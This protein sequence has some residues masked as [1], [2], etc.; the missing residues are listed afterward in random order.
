MQRTMILLG[1]LLVAT[2]GCNDSGGAI[3]G[4]AQAQQSRGNDLQA[5]LSGSNLIITTD[6]NGDLTPTTEAG[7]SVGV[8]IAKGSGS[9][10]FQLRVAFTDPFPAP[11]GSCP[12]ELPFAT[13]LTTTNLVLTYAD[14]S[15]LELSSST[16]TACSNGVIFAV[17]IEEGTVVGGEGR[18]DGADGTWSATVEQESARLTGELEVDLNW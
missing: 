14:G 7:V 4:V 17:S 2:A 16:G 11:D 9:A 5:R 10:T 15:I 12:D 18:F 3:G 8:G 13:D 1:L 6:E